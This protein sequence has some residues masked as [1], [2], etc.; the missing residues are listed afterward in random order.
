MRKTPSGT[1]GNSWKEKMLS[2]I[3]LKIWQFLNCLIFRRDLSKLQ[4]FHT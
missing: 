4:K 1:S 2:A 3:R